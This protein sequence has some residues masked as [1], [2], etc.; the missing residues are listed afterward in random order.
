MIFGQTTLWTAIE[1]NNFKDFDQR[2]V[3]AKMKL[4]NFYLATSCKMYSVSS[5]T[6]YGNFS[7]NIFHTSVIRG[8]PSLRPHFHIKNSLFCTKEFSK[9]RRLSGW[10]SIPVHIVYKLEVTDCLKPAG[11]SLASIQQHL[12][13]NA[14]A[15]SISMNGH[16]Y[17]S[18]LTRQNTLLAEIVGLVEKVKLGKTVKLKKLQS[19]ST[20]WSSSNGQNISKASIGQNAYPAEMV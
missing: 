9:C 15:Q 19:F 14:N 8:D 18:G 4:T 5:Q 10:K 2:A 12:K 16:T 11:I 20:G 3:T 6:T 1:S 7:W 17:F 13:N